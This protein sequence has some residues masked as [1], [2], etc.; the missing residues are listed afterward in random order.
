M[1][2]WLVRLAAWLLN[3]IATVSDGLSPFERCTGRRFKGKQVRFRDGAAQTTRRW[4]AQFVELVM[5]I[6]Q[7]KLH[8]SSP[9]R[10]CQRRASS[11]PWSGALHH[12]CSWLTFEEVGYGRIHKRRERSR[13]VAVVGGYGT[14][15]QGTQAFSKRH[16]TFSSRL[17]SSTRNTTLQTPSREEVARRDADQQVPQLTVKT[18]L[19]F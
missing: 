10:C 2:A 14:M 13:S 4:S 19:V 11:L 18:H 5:W 15:M 16:F 9:S 6:G 3:R 8:R 12:S 17:V 1:V 7:R